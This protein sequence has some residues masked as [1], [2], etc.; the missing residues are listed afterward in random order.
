MQRPRQV[1]LAL[2]RFKNDARNVVSPSSEWRVRSR[3]KPPRSRADT[4]GTHKPAV[5]SRPFRGKSSR[6]TSAWR[7]A[8]RTEQKPTAKLP[9]VQSCRAP[10]EHRCAPLFIAG[11]R[12]TAEAKLDTGLWR[13]HLKFAICANASMKLRRRYRTARVVSIL[14]KGPISRL[15]PLFNL[16]CS[17]WSTR[18]V[19]CGNAG[20]DRKKHK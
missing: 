8:N 3:K 18:F 6:A 7:T 1:C 2:P 9:F 17:S 14:S 12:G 10:I 19:V 13:R 5:H 20:V 4:T 15:R 16:Y 11:K